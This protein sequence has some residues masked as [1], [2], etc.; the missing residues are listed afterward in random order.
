MTWLNEEQKELIFDYC[1]GLTD[2]EKSVEARSLICSNEQANDIYSNLK[3][4]LQPLESIADELCPDELV[5]RTVI[6]VNDVARSSAERLQQLIA[7]EQNRTAAT[8]QWSW[9]GAVR[10]LATAAVFIIAGS[11]LLTTFNYMRY[12]YLQQRCQLQQS[13][14]FGGL[15]NYMADHDGRQPAI[16]MQSGAPWYKIGYQGRENQ[17]NTRRVFLLVKNGYIEADS[18]VCPACGRSP[19][20]LTTS[21]IETLRDFPDRRYITYSFRIDCRKNSGGELHCRKVLLADLSP[22]FEN[23]PDDYG[24]PFEL[25]LNKRLLTINSINHKRKG[26]NVLFGDGHVEFVKKR[27]I[28]HLSTDDIFTLRNTDVYRGYETPSCTTDFF[29]AP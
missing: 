18:L 1:M 12:D 24:K 19:K 28:D 29:L 13:G 11:V 27:F 25:Q 16:A 4:T 23:L 14:F 8:A 10:R 2:P 7:D 21:Q 3:S 6:R 9:F 15:S 26:Q 17:S 20:K 22:L 5:E